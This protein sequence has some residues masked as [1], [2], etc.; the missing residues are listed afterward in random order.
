MRR[1]GLLIALII[2]LGLGLAA[3]AL[4]MRQS[5]NTSGEAAKEKTV[6]V[7]VMKKS[8]PRGVRIAAE[9][10][11]LKEWP[12]RLAV[13][14]FLRKIADVK[15]RVLVS[16]VVKGEPLVSNKMAPEKSVEGLS[17][18]IPKGKRAFAVRVNDVTGVSGFLLPGS[19]VDV[20]VTIESDEIDLGE[21]TKKGKEKKR[22]EIALAKTILQDVEVLAA[23]EKMEA[24][25][26]KKGQI[27]TPVVTLL[28]T[29]KEG[30]KLALAASKGSIWLSLRNPRDKIAVPSRVLTIQELLALDSPTRRIESAPK[31]K[32]TGETAAPKKKK[33]ARRRAPKPRTRI[34]VEILH[35]GKSKTVQ[36]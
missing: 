31:A 8:L 19:R 3:G 22:K 10:V 28:L 26:S 9:D 16:N 13:S 35:G 1:R 17:T 33:T 14:Q 32:A 4:V 12:E 5:G 36:F 15:N 11:E 25:K 7:V 30:E 34:S 21:G 20:L 2:A 24:G 18:L 27:R 29:P 23:G 6:K